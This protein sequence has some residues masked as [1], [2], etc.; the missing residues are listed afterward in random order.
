[1]LYAQLYLQHE[2]LTRTEFTAT[3]LQKLFLWTKRVYLTENTVTVVNLS[4]HVK[5]CDSITHSLI[6]RCCIWGDI[7]KLTVL[8]VKNVLSLSHTGACNCTVS[9]VAPQSF[10]RHHAYIRLTYEVQTQNNLTYST[11]SFHC[12][13]AV[14]IPQ[15]AV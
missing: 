1:M 11:Q 13:D 9:S 8:N 15:T 2:V 12:T 6:Q 14:R 3:Q 10:V 7:N 5:K 4:P